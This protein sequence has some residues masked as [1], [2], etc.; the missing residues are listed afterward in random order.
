M[1]RMK[2]WWIDSCRKAGVLVLAALMLATLVSLPMARPV[3]A[4]GLP[5]PGGT[6]QNFTSSPDQVSDGTIIRI[7]FSLKTLVQ[8]LQVSLQILPFPSVGPG[9][10]L[11][12]VDVS[13]G[14]RI[15]AGA[16][17]VHI[18]WPEME[19]PAG[20]E[21]SGYANFRVVNPQPGTTIQVTG[22]FTLTDQDGTSYTPEDTLNLTVT[23]SPLGPLTILKNADRSSVNAG[24]SY[25][26][27]IT[28]TNPNNQPAQNVRVTDTLDSYLNPQVG[29][30][31]GPS[32]SGNTLTWTL[33]GPIYP[34]QSY[35]INLTVQVSTSAPDGYQINNVAYVSATGL[36][37]NQDA[38]LP[39]VVRNAPQPA[40]VMSMTS[41]PVQIAAGGRFRHTVNF[42][43]GNSPLIT[44]A[45]FQVVLPST[46]TFVAASGG[47]TLNG[48]VV[49]WF[50]GNAYPN[51]SLQFTLDLQAASNLPAGSVIIDSVNFQG[52]TSP[53]YLFINTSAQAPG[54]TITAPAITLA[55]QVD[56]PNITAGGKVVFTVVAQNISGNS[57][58]NCQLIYTVDPNLTG[59]SFNPLPAS[60][61]GN[62]YTWNFGYMAAQQIVKVVMNG[63]V[64]AGVAAGRTL[65]NQAVFTAAGSQYTASA[66]VYISSTPPP[67]VT[68]FPDVPNFYWAYNEISAMVK[69]G[70]ITGYPDGTYK[71]D[72]P[73]TRAEFCKMVV[74]ALGLA[75]VPSVRPNF[76][77]LT[78]DDQWAWPYMQA[79]V[80]NR[81]VT[82]FPDGTFRPRETVTEAQIFAIIVRAKNWSLVNP[83]SSVAIY[84]AEDPPTGN[85]NYDT[86][87]FTAATCW[88]YQYVWTA[89][90]NGILMVPDDPHQITWQGPVPGSYMYYF[91]SAAYRAETAVYLYR[92]LGGK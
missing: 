4:I 15:D 90:Q 19:M 45:F 11:A 21:L 69:A 14:L 88:Y 68:T 79:A 7:D 75:P 28:I 53:G 60:Q 84:V 26:Y 76:P 54:V 65:T 49:Q 80:A 81:L 64:A 71:P 42:S 13:P 22:R 67:V 41:D 32:R 33:L 91:N 72:N 74:L 61:N 12:I 1:K 16:G 23:S 46:I 92:M 82:G 70:V 29:Q 2:K 43:S 10:P 77:D 52:R 27:N 50:I 89:V 34:G 44:G 56:P 62:T 86:R 37:Q 30:I 3:S 48:N 35:A 9:E 85:P 78:P 51:Q 66:G 8:V 36:P 39:V 83:L 6:W 47:G 18:V 24:D 59:L 40:Y 63:T 5:N 73:V 20:A 38:A 57:L 58:Q 25:T 17:Q 55:Q 87:P 31:G